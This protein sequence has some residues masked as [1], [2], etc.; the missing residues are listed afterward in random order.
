MKLGCVM[1]AFVPVPAFAL[2]GFSFGQSHAAFSLGSA[3]AA[4]APSAQV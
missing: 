4:V 1:A 2:D 3:M